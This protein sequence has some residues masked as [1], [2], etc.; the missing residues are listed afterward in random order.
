M[1]SSG[2]NSARG[3]A[4]RERPFELVDN[5]AVAVEAQ[6][7]EGDGGAQEVAAYAFEF[8]ALVVLTGDRGV[9]REAVV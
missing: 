4:V 7:L 1:K 5:E 9:Q 8:V 3:C 2:S 6:A